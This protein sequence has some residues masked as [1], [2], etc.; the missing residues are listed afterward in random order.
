MNQL[1]AS[2][3]ES[4]EVASETIYVVSSFDFGGTNNVKIHAA[5]ADYNLAQ[6]VYQSVR[7]NSDLHYDATNSTRLLVEL[8]PIPPGANAITLFWGSTVG[9]MN[10]NE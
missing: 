4:R 5:S 1:T 6:A 8:T 2:R 10:N 7:A 9:A 3:V